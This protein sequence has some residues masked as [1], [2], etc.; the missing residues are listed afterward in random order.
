MKDLNFLNEGQIFPPIEEAKRVGA[1]A[2]YALMYDG[3]SYAVE[4][5]HFK[6]TAKNLNTLALLLGWTNSY[7]AVDYN[8]YQVISKKTMDFICGDWPDIMASNENDEIRQKE[9]EEIDLIRE[10]TNFDVKHGDAW[11]DVSK[12]GSCP[13]RV[14][15]RASTDSWAAASV[16]TFTLLDPAMVYEI[17]DPEDDYE[18]ICYVICYLIPKEKK[19]KVQIHKIGYYD[20]RIYA[21]DVAS[22][23]DIIT[24]DRYVLANVPNTKQDMY[25]LVRD[26]LTEEIFRYQGLKL[27]K[28]ISERKNIKTGLDSFAIITLDNVRKSDKITRTSDYDCISPII[29][30]IQRTMTQVQMIFDKYTVPTIYGDPYMLTKYDSKGHKYEDE[31]VFEIGKF[32]GVPPNGM[33][34]GILEVDVGK[35]QMY[36]NQIQENLKILKEVSEMGAA[37]SS[38][39]AVSG[40][41]TETMGARFQSVKAKARR[42]TT[43]NEGKIKRLFSLVSEFYDFKI[44]IEDITIKWYDGLPTDELKEVQIAQTK[45][46]GGFSSHRH[47]CTTRFNYTQSQFEDYWDEYLTE[48]SDMNTVRSVGNAFN[49]FNP[50]NSQEKV[51]T[52]ENQ[53][54]EGK[55]DNDEEDNRP[56]EKNG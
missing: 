50:Q 1:Y 12:Y 38:D 22:D 35:L 27:K 18:I 29:S 16:G 39:D 26:R 44:P 41:S 23:T 6:E 37:L 52:D 21:V 47:E 33:I 20:E 51:D 24:S 55:N 5:K 45:V 28:L 40:I 46:D 14:Y 36:F 8:Y 53:P 25:L 2:D 13:I 15:N 19:M 10:R 48:L 31:S 34:P 43:R 54:R 56:Y 4:E 7:C 32:L 49:P 17:T 42:L 3:D 30:S 11:I 9:Q